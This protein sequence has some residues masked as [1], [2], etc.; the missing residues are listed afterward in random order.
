M[1]ENKDTTKILVVDDEDAAAQEICEYL[2]D[3]NY[4][5]L[6]ATDSQVA[7]QLIQSDSQIKLILLDIKMPKMDGIELMKKIQPKI[8]TKLGVIMFSGHSGETEIVEGMR[9]NAMD[10]LRKPIE[11]KELLKSIKNAI[12]N[13]NKSSSKQ[14]SNAYSEATTLAREFLQK[15]EQMVEEKNLTEQNSNPP[16]RSTQRVLDLL[17]KSFQKQRD[18]GEISLRIDPALLMMFELYHPNN[19]QGISVTA[20][21]NSGKTAQTTAL[22]RIQ[23]LEVAGYVKRKDDA[24]DKRRAVLT[25]TQNGID[26]IDSYAKS[27]FSPIS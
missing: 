27:V 23:D 26:A 8:G 5:C 16:T 10:F 18:F 13:L 15:L 7:L 25:L 4:K 9:N 24:K 17:K 14:V 22:R 20:L 11:P 1:F 19:S 21:C 2:E 6:K 3:A 12:A